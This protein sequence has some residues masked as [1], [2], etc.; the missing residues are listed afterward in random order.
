MPNAGRSSLEIPREG[1]ETPHGRLYPPQSMGRQIAV[2]VLAFFAGPAL[3]WLIAELPADLSEAARTMLQIPFVLIYLAGYALWVARLHALAFELIGWS[4]FRALFT[5]L[6]HRR[7]PQSLADVMPTR[8]KLLQLMVR[9][10][11]A[12]AAFATVSVPIGLVAGAAATLF[13][14]RLGAAA[15]FTLAAA[16][17]IGWGYLLAW[18]GRHGWLPFAEEG[19]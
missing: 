7:K 15:L 4:L 10:Q 14:S 16:S 5:L 8:E 13:D 11:Q 12:A 9:A 6:V 3:G 18:L 1:L 2:F 17:C 19:Q